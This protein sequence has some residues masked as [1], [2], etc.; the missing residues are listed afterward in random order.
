MFGDC[1]PCL[2]WG[3]NRDFIERQRDCGLALDRQQIC[4][5]LTRANKVNC[6]VKKTAL[7]PRSRV[8]R[9]NIEINLTEKYPN[10]IVINAK[11]EACSFI[12]ELKQSQ[13]LPLTYK[14]QSNC[15]DR[16]IDTLIDFYFTISKESSHPSSFSFKVDI[17]SN[18]NKIKNTIRILPAYKVSPFRKGKLVNTN[19]FFQRGENYLHLIDI[20]RFGPYNTNK[21]F[22][23]KLIYM[24]K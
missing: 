22:F 3:G 21:T 11:D 23:E 15:L 5:A 8:R 19:V 7:N 13:S 16:S 12:D 20:G 14:F 17:D 2:G 24:A 4:T 10:A 18:S 6:G 1:L 9:N